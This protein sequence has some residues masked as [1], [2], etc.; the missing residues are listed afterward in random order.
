ML[1][2]G[3]PYCLLN[4]Y[5]PVPRTQLDCWE[6]RSAST[7]LCRLRNRTAYLG[8]QKFYCSELHTAFYHSDKSLTMNVQCS[9]CHNDTLYQAVYYG[10][11]GAVEW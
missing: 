9:E 8:S 1:P 10:Q 2:W 5:S 7:D 3:T 6:G 11:P 4:Q